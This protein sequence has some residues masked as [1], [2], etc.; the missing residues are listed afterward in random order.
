M[1]TMFLFICPT[2]PRRPPPPLPQGFNLTRR[3]PL[4]VRPKE[5]LTRATGTGTTSLL[6]LAHWH[7]GTLA[8]AGAGAG[9]GTDALMKQ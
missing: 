5:K 8:R 9:A 6:L 4:W 1:R 2:D 7:T 3:M